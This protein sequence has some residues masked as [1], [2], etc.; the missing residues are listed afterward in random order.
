MHHDR[1]GE[2]M[3]FFAR[4]RLDPGLHAK[5]L[6]PGDALEEGVDKAHNGGGCQQLG[7]KLCTFGNAARH[8]G[9]NGCGKRQQEEELDQSVSTVH[10]QGFCADKEV[11]AIGNAIAHGEIH[12]GGD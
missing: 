9:G 7:P 8:D 5:M 11:G 4:Q 10:C 1:T 2:V 6:V 3:K 12:H